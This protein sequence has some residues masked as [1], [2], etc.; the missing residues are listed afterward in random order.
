MR[1]VAQPVSRGVQRIM[2]KAMKK[3]LG[4]S[5]IEL[6]IVVAIVGLLATIAYP[7]Y[8][9][10]LIRGRIPD[11]ASALAA[12]RVQMEQYFQDNRTY[13]GAPACDADA[14]TSRFFTFSCNPAATATTY[15][16]EAVGVAPMKA[17]PIRLDRQIPKPQPSPAT[18]WADP[19]PT[20]AGSSGKTVAAHEPESPGGDDP[21]RTDDRHRVARHPA[22]VGRADLFP[23][24]T[25][26][27]RSATPPR[28]SRMA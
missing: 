27:A 20:I 1:V 24:D 5:L 21:D 23:L 6:M 14:T 26:T 25:R 22:G 4:F 13:V 2:R 9:D 19:S 15:T 28:P 16:L 12:K 17:S 18:G 7:A 3:Q 11:A 8:S 10:Y